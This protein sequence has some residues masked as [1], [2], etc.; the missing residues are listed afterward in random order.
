MPAE[1][2]P[3]DGSEHSDLDDELRV[4]TPLSMSSSSA[5]SIDSSMERL[6]ILDDEEEPTS[7]NV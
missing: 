3:S 4:P 6:N 1:N 5:P 7:Q 2:A